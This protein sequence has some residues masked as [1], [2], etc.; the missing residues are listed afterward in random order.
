MDC[1][2]SGTRFRKFAAMGFGYLS[3]LILRSVFLVPVIVDSL[4][5]F[6][7]ASGFMLLAQ[8]L[9]ITAAGP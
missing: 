7:R 8:Q 3:L 9:A 1:T 5:L 6:Q 2:V 4:C